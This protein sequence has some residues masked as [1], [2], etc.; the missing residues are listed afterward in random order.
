[1]EIRSMPDDN[2]K[3]ARKCWKESRSLIGMKVLM[4]AVVIWLVT[5]TLA[6]FIAGAMHFGKVEGLQYEDG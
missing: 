6:V 1:M 4:Y 5:F 3:R 2:S